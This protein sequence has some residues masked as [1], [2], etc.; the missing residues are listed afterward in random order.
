[1]QPLG[2][3]LWGPPGPP[4]TQTW[5]QS[6][7]QLPTQK[8]VNIHN[9]KENIFKML[10]LAIGA[11]LRAPGPLLWGPLGPPETRRLGASL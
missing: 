11:V 6:I 8:L 10:F 1:M 5:G 9:F 2:L 4:Y 3:H 7:I